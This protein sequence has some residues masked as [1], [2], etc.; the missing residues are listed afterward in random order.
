MA[1]A[2]VSILPSFSPASEIRMK[3]RKERREEGRK[4]VLVT[5]AGKLLLP[6]E[7]IAK[8]EENRK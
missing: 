6:T 7:I 1:F 4:R 3:E 5:T 8:G 2:Q